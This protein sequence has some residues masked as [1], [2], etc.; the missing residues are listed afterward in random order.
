MNWT[1]NALPDLRGQN[2]FIT[3]GNSGIGL[4]AAK[5]L[6][7][8]GAQVLIGARSQEKA[9]AALE[10][11]ATHAPGAQCGWV[12]L[13]LTDPQSIESAAAAVKEKLPTLHALI[14]NAGVMQTPDRLTPEGHEL[15]L[16]TN[17]LG[18]FRL[19]AA[20]YPHLVAAEGRIVVVSSIAHKSG[21]IDFDDLMG[22]QSYSPLRAYGQ[23]KLANLLFALELDRRLKQANSPV[24]CIPCHPGYSSTNLFSAGLG[25]EGGSRFF[26]SLYGLSTSLMAQSA[27]RGAYPLVLAAAAPEAEAGCYYGPTGLGEMRGAVGLAKI[28]KHAKDEALLQ[29]FWKTTE[30]LVGPFPALD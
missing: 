17:H 13:D 26:R 8:K 21:K 3:G 7:E 14:N 22:R 4:E 23:S 15:Q 18:H 27:V 19:T 16:A 12:P 29:R 9:E 1:P 20:L 30:S 11:I 6:C 25:M 24:Q 10:A 2:Y 28:A 5:I